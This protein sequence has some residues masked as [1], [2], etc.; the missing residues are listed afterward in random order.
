MCTRYFMELS[1]ELRPIIEEARRSSLTSRMVDKLGKD[2]VT[3]GEVRPGNMVPVI[4]PD[5][6]GSRRTYPMVW[7]Y[8]VPGLKRPLVNA[9]SETAA[10]K[11]SF[12]ESWRRRRCLIPSSWYFEWDHI[13]RGG[14][15]ITGDKYAI[16]T[17]DRQVT[18]LAGLYQIENLANGFRYPTFA[19]LTREPTPDLAGIHDRMPLVLSEEVLD[20]WIYPGTKEPALQDMMTG[21]VTSLVAEKY[22][23]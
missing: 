15:R 17:R 18:W 22:L 16:Q 9:R 7:G 11:S 23:P 6:S 1:P 4:A 5:Q 14:R 2:L 13:E 12:R 21:S 19:I 3:E 8:A 10:V 20:S